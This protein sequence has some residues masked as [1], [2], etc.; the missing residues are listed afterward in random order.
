[1]S[2][3]PEDVRY[4]AKLAELAV[5]DSELTELTAQ[6]DRIVSFVAQLESLGDPT[7]VERYVAGPDA[8]TL[9]GDVARPAGLVRTPAEFA[10]EFVEGFFVVPRLGAMEEP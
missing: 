6:M 8:T 5:E 4:V 7:R 1:M 2:V 10:P 9:R 3:T